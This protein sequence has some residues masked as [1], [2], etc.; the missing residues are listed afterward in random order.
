MVSFFK[1]KSTS[2]VFALV[3]ASACV[4]AFF[5]VHP[6]QLITV[7]ED[8]IIYYLISPL[9]NLPGILLPLL[10]QLIVM[11]Q[12]LRLNYALN[13][14]RLYSKPA[15]T[16]ALAYILLTALFPD[17]NNITAALVINSMLI[18]LLY[19]IIKLYNSQQPKTLIFNIGLITG[20]TIL[21][22]FPTLP[23]ILV[24]FFT[25]ATFRPFRLNEWL[26]LLIG[27]IAPFYFFG[28]WLY[29]TDRSEMALR[30]LQ[31]FQLHVIRPANLP[32]TVTTLAIT[33]AAIIA[34]I[35]M[36]QSNSGRM[37]IQV[38]KSWG[39]LFLMLLLLI[40]SVFIIKGA[41]PGALLMAAVPASAFV[42]NAFLYPKR[43][44]VAAIIFWVFVALIIYNNWVAVKVL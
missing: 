1:E 44:F 18:W 3:I 5:W 34:G 4:R 10:Y 30:Q 15:F 38:R 42:A 32:L 41:W 23:L 27:I 28:A 16:T 9:L 39:V 17:W 6:P 8:G 35:F 11:I 21:L 24:M 13:D 25:I 7:P 20:T 36:W 2:G 22:Y 33:G 40:P 37:I 14:V 26:I 12:A 19:R 43:N 31:I 29:I